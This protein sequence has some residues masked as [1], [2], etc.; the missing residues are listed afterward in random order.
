[1]IFGRKQWPLQLA[2]MASLIVF[3][4][5]SPIRSQTGSCGNLQQLIKE[6]YNFK[7][8]RLSE[9]EQTTKSHAMDRVW[10]AVKDN[11]DAL[12]PCLRAALA[13]SNAD[14]YFR[15][16]GSN[17]LT[18]LDPS[19]ESKMSLIR[20]YAL[21][22]LNDV[23]L[24]VWVTRLSGLGFQGFDVSEA[25]D[26]WLRYANATYYLP[27]HGAYKVTP[28]NGAMFLYGSMDEAHATPALL[29]I[30]LDKSHPGR[31]IALWAFM[32][33][34]TPE[35]L[36][37]LKRINKA[38]FSSKAQ[39]SLTA[40]LTRPQLFEARPKPTTSRQEIVTAF[41]KLLQGDAAHFRKLTSVVADGERDVVAVLTP[42]DLPLVRKVRRFL[43]AGGNP[44]SI[45]YYNSFS[46]ILMTFVWKPGL[47]Q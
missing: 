26:K 28:A 5:A 6:T 3:A 24:R 31:E 39:S 8:A 33:Q 22:D 10:D 41:E 43:I 9:S 19:R 44:H 18:S 7:P 4:A 25:A 11:R 23:D 12:L 2:A 45:E 14:G 17:L 47:V 27:E 20:A 21:V 35:S 34:A 29:K 30:V 37:A 40:L 38:D 1:M 15:F 36:Q 42:D 46:T 16:D 13:D 32:N